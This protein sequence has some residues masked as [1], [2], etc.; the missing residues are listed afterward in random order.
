MRTARTR[1][2]LLVLEVEDTTRSRP[3]PGGVE[4]RGQ[5]LGQRRGQVQVRVGDDAVH[6][7]GTQGAELGDDLG[8]RLDAVDRPGG[9]HAGPPGQLAGER[10][11][12]AHGRRGRLRPRCGRRERARV[13]VTVGDPSGS[14]T[15][16]RACCSTR[17]AAR[18]DPGVAGVLH[19][20]AVVARRAGGC[21]DDLGARTDGPDARGVDAEVVERQG[22]IGFL[23]A[24][25]I[26]LKLG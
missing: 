16:R 11:Q 2:D 6:V 17:Y 12:L 5:G 7:V 18:P 3:R 23:R 13:A 8:G 14:G 25:M 4:E 10:E 26:P 1:H 20:H 19:E 9:M 22:V 15:V 24:A 21:L